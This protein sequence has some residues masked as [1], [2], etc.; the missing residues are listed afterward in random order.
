TDFPV[1][2]IFARKDKVFFHNDRDFTIEYI[3]ADMSAARTIA[4]DVY[5]TE[6][7]ISGERLYYLSGE[8]VRSVCSVKLDG[9]DAKTHIDI[10]G[11]HS[12]MITKKGCFIII[13]GNLYRL[14]L[15][16]KKYKLIKENVK[17]FN[18]D[19]DTL[20]FVSPDDKYLYK[21][22][23]SNTD[24]VTKTSVYDCN[25]V[26]IANGQVFTPAY[27]VIYRLEDGGYA[28]YGRYKSINEAN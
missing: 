7:N 17:S 15:A 24:A 10:G 1:S 22:P 5:G 20:Y 13:E 26:G 14:D 11:G 25:S 28:T 4:K 6:M 18:I 9:S 27:D 21:C 23:L 3:T 16:A 8:T 12:F 2:N 19:G